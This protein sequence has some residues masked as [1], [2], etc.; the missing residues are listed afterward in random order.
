MSRELNMDTKR[1]NFWKESIE[2]EAMARVLARQA[3]L[4]KGLTPEKMIS[5]RKQNGEGRIN[6]AKKMIPK[7]ELGNVTLPPITVCFLFLM[8]KCFLYWNI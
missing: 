3:R 6:R 4:D 5:Q 1:M 8:I 7:V 2:K